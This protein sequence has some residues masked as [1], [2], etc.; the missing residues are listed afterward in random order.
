MNPK[1]LILD[2][3]T[4]PKIAYV[5]KFWQQNVSPKQV[6]DHG[7]LASFG[8][9]WLGSLDLI[10]EENRKEND[11]KIIQSLSSLLDEADMVVMHNGDRFDLPEIR[12]RAL[13]HGIKP[14]SPVKTVDTYKIAKREFN[15]PSNSLEYLTIVLGCKVKKGGHKKFPGFELWLECL[16]QNEEAWIEMK[17]YNLLDVLALEEV[18][19]KMRPWDH[20]HPNLAIYN[21][22]ILPQCPKCQSQR[23]QRRGHSYTA[24]GKYQR[25][26]CLDCGGWSRGKYTEL[27]KNE[28][29]L[30]NQ[31]K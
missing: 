17:E 1:I 26:V 27:K 15:F 14:F 10:Y 4:M 9:K 6:I 11:Y 13:V 7:H 8:A 3:E 23:Q 22:P 16:R 30:V 5:W 12:G 20:L 31:V 19:L 28:N 2:I 29:L 21:D 18:Y 24:T 25:F